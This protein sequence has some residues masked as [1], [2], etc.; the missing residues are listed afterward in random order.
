[1]SIL[2]TAVT[3]AAQDQPRLQSVAG[4]HV[5]VVYFDT[6]L[7]AVDILDDRAWDDLTRAWVQ[8]SRATGALAALPLALSFRSWLEVLQGRLGSAASHLA[9]IE[10]VVSLTRSRGCSEHRLRRTCCATRGWRTRRRREPE[11]GA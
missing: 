1:M 7:A 3:S 2:H 8:L 10:D 4:R 11:R 6:V 5:H 9:E